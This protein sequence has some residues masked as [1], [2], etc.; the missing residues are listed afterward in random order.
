MRAVQ[1]HG[2]PHDTSVPYLF[3]PAEH[4]HCRNA[5]GVRQ[6]EFTP[7]RRIS[8]NALAAQSPVG[9]LR[10]ALTGKAY[11]HEPQGKLRRRR[12]TC[13]PEHGVLAGRYVR[14]QN[15]PKGILKFFPL[16]IE[17]EHP[18]ILRHPELKEC[19]RYESRVTEILYPLYGY[20]RS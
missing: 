6:G 2:G 12:E 15:A 7:Q 11:G 20:L 9:G 5:P 3:S 1:S 13:K 18:C 4:F 16:D 14:E 17:T 8:R 10:H 19:G